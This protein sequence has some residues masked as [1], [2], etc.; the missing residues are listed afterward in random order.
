MLTKTKSK[1]LKIFVSKI[2]QRFSIREISL[3]L[4]MKYPL[5]HR[6]IKPLIEEGYILK[7]NKELRWQNT[8]THTALSL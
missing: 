1:I 7:D 5:V 8:L 4:K 3:L 6:S 2:N